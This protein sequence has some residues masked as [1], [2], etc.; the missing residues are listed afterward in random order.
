M[1]RLLL[2]KGILAAGCL[3]LALVALFPPRRERVHGSPAENG[4]A[5]LSTSEEPD[6]PR[7][8]IFALRDR[9]I[10]EYKV[11]TETN[12]HRVLTEIETGRLLVEALL[13]IAATGMC[14]AVVTRWQQP[15]NNML[16]PT[17]P[18]SLVPNSSAV[19]QASPA[20]ELKRSR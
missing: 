13:I 7:V 18:A 12:G 9:G 20:A 6:I 19:P 14:L 2:A 10:H 1:V 8:Y 4:F 3:L 11:H 17:E 15:P 5:Q 16:Q